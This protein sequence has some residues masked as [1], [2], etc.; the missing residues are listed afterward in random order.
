MQF[1]STSTSRVGYV[2]DSGFLGFQLE[3]VQKQIYI[4]FGFVLDFINKPHLCKN[5]FEFETAKT[6]S[7]IGD[8]F[9]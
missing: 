4:T 8:G 6:V 2:I 3:K 7:L 5:I 9:F 1:S